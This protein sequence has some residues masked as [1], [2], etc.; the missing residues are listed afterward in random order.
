MC[1]GVPSVWHIQYASQADAIMF[2]DELVFR[3][4]MAGGHP[5]NY[6]ANM[7]NAAR[8]GTLA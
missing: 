7:T 6:I 4:P 3:T 8:N 1:R 2:I 5:T